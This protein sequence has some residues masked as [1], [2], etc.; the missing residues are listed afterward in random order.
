M[1]VL[2]IYVY[3]HPTP[4]GRLPP[5]NPPAA[6][7]K[8]MTK[9]QG[10]FPES[11]LMRMLV[12]RL[13]GLDASTYCW[14]VLRVCVYYIHTRTYIRTYIYVVIRLID[15]MKI[16]GRPAWS[17]G[18]PWA[19]CSTSTPSSR[20]RHVVCV[21]FLHYIIILYVCACPRIRMDR[22]SDGSTDTIK[23]AHTRT[24]ASTGGRLVLRRQGRGAGASRPFLL[25]RIRTSIQ[26]CQ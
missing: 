25:I 16:T 1:C 7:T 9:R 13:P 3:Y 10:P 19:R 17:S 21:L 14:C 6:T 8:P 23:H 15:P 2:F 5:P 24:R 18:S 11:T 26:S 12:K 22:P 4:S 20:R